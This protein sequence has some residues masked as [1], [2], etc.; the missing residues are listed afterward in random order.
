MQLKD[1]VT[2]ELKLTVLNKKGMELDKDVKECFTCDLLSQVLAKAHR[3]SIWVTIQNHMNVIGVA[4]MLDLK[5][6]IISDDKEVPPEV[7][8]KADSEGVL[9]LS[10][11]LSSFETSGRLYERGLR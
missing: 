8:E 2:S 4:T 7:V 1:I 11:P 9:L 10:T 5:A 6:V 3:G